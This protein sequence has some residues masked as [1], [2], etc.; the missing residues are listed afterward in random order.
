MGKN[1]NILYIGP[2][3]EFGGAGN[4]ARNYIQALFESGHDVCIAPIFYTG[5]TYPENEISS[6][7]LPLENNTLR[8][9]DIVIQHCNPFDYVY[10]NKFDI[11]IGI[12]QF[13]SGVI[14]NSILSRL[15]LM[16]RIVVNS[17]FN[18]NVINKSAKQEL[19][20]K[21]LVCPELIDTRLKN[22]EYPEYPWINHNSVVF[23]TIADLIERKNI[24]KIIT[25][26]LYT[27]GTEDKAEL[28]IKTKPH[29]SHRENDLVN[30]EIQYMIDKIYKTLRLDKNHCKQPKIMVGAFEHRAVLGVHKNANIY[31]DASMAE[32]FGYSVLEAALF[33]NY[34]IVNENSSTSEISSSC[35]LTESRP[36]NIT[37]SYT[38][39]FMENTID[40]YWYDVD[41]HHL[42]SNMQTAYFSGLGNKCVSHDL[43]KY[44]YKNV[45]NILI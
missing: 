43:S 13:N 19:V 34:L 23:Y 12:Y 30:K 44:A 36:I 10:S 3:R 18:F 5:D 8:N 32:N 31:I 14:N 15:N 35:L 11:N 22:K 7:I 29:Y 1:K 25:A 41:F 27:F 2:Y 9:Y 6:D 16:D 26:F 45:E 24:Q 21:I 4:S 39:T 42:C 20:D 37:D 40:Q 38:N 33:D 17:T 28:I